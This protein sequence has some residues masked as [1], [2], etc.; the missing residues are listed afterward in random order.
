MTIL[1]DLST[2]KVETWSLFSSCCSLFLPQTGQHLFCLCR[3]LTAECMN[4]CTVSSGGTDPYIIAS[5]VIC[6]SCG[7]KSLLSDRSTA[8]HFF[9]CFQLCGF[10]SELLIL[11]LHS[12]LQARAVSCKKHIVGSFSFC[13]LIHCAALCLSLRISDLCKSNVL[14]IGKDSQMP[15]FYLFCNICSFILLCYLHW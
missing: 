5:F 9:R 4:N 12:Y 1:F 13:F 11:S 15:F 14:I 6:V 8:S 10:L 2:L 7:L 3:C